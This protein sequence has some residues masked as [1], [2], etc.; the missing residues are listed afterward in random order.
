V[1]AACG[2]PLPGHQ[3]LFSDLLKTGNIVLG[4]DL[5]HFPKERTRNRV[6]PRDFNPQ[7]TAA[8]RERW[9]FF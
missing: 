8:T 7:Q 2:Q 4:G 3:V 6:P 5:Y 9:K 1:A